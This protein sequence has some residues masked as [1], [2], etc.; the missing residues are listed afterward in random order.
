MKERIGEILNNERD[1][2]E[3]RR[4][5]K[6]GRREFRDANSDPVPSRCVPPQEA[7]RHKRFADVED[8]ALRG[9]KAPCD[10]GQG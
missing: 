10:I 8:T 2:L 7:F 9:L 5:V 1:R 3:A 6:L 4:I